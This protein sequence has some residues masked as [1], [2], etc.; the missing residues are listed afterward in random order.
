MCG[1]VVT[2]SEQSGLSRPLLIG[3]VLSAMLAVSVW[4]AAEP[5]P[6][7]VPWVELPRASVEK[8]SD[9]AR[10]A[11]SEASTAPV[12]SLFEGGF[13]DFVGPSLVPS[14]RT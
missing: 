2:G 5:V 8:G 14:L 11:D 13:C 7:K 12:P 9:W 6:D 10:K 4:L 3:D 1:D